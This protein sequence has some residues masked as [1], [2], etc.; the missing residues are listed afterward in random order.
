MNEIH[1]AVPNRE[2]GSAVEC[3]GVRGDA[4]FDSAVSQRREA[5]EG[6]WVDMPGVQP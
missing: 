2:V 5:S 4:G 6:S 3:V 1:P